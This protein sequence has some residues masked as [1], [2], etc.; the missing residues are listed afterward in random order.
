MHNMILIENRISSRGRSTGRSHRGNSENLARLILGAS[1]AGLLYL[2]LAAPPAAAQSPSLQ[3]AKARYSMTPADGGFIRLDTETGAL[4]FCSNKSGN[5]TCNLMPD[6]KIALEQQIESL[7]KKNRELIEDN[8]RLEDMVLG[9][10]KKPGDGSTNK[11]PTFKLPSE[12]EVDQALGYVERM[13]KKFRD[14][15]RD[16]EKENKD[17]KKDDDG[18]GTEL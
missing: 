16:L 9:L 5:F 13:Y 17:L 8:K 11:A 1:F 18:K 3:P 4:S 2:L 15:L 6:D 10:D 14:K 12:K 7:K